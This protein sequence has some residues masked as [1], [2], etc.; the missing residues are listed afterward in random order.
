M[1][2]YLSMIPAFNFTNM[3]RT[4]V[5]WDR[6][7]AIIEAR[8]RHD[9]YEKGWFFGTTLM[10]LNMQGEMDWS[11][12]FHNAIPFGDALS[13]HGLLPQMYDN[14]APPEHRGWLGSAGRLAVGAVSNFVGNTPLYN[15][16][17]MAYSGRDEFTGRPLFDPKAGPLERT[18]GYLK[19]LGKEFLPPMAP[20]GRDFTAIQDSMAA[21]VSSITRRPKGRAGELAIRSILNVDIRGL[22][23]LLGLNSG[24]KRNPVVNDDDLIVSTLYRVKTRPEF[25]GG[26]FDEALESD[27]REMKEIMGRVMDEA[28]SPEE[29]AKALADFDEVMQQDYDV[30]MKGIHAGM[31]KTERQA[32][33]AKNRIMKDGVVERFGAQRLDTQ[34]MTI[35]LLDQYD[36]AQDKLLELVTATKY[37]DQASFDRETDPGMVRRALEILAQ[38]TDVPGHS[39]HLDELERHL[40]EYALPMAE[41][42]FK[43]ESKLLDVK[44]QRVERIREALKQRGQ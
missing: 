38:R 42:S 14:W 16:A 11:M 43:R 3:I 10:G 35:A 31:S 27:N 28:R 12:D 13:G 26:T 29:R 22:S 34:A 36:I 39:A 44:Q 5:N 4:G 21:G 9:W 32:M 30:T 1:L 19:L 20:F 41:A 17:G 33:L 6:M 25:G 8:G 37:T 15:A 7:E 40:R 2:G 23:N 24:D 18:A